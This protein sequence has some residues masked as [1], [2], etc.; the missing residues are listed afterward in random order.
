MNGPQCCRLN[1]TNTN[2]RTVRNEETIPAP[3]GLDTSGSGG[4]RILRSVR[5][6]SHSCRRPTKTLERS[7]FFWRSGFR[8][9][10]TCPSVSCYSWI[11]DL[12]TFCSFSQ[13]LFLRPDHVSPWQSQRITL[14]IIRVSVLSLFSS[15][16]HHQ[17]LTR[18]HRHFV[19]TTRDTSLR[20]TNLFWG[21]LHSL[22]I[23]RD[24]ISKILLIPPLTSASF[25][26]VI[27]LPWYESLL[28]SPIST[29]LMCPC[30]SHSSNPPSFI[31]F[32]LNR[33][34]GS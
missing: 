5:G 31:L 33:P 25:T 1:Q 14:P 29:N 6:S 15:R 9:L 24:L 18:D 3:C 17:D 11:G 23:I 2:K 4:R 28:I 7:G 20:F 30:F 8:I 13:L 32:D 21:Y 16:P 22:F 10:D 12:V 34:Q 19:F 27:I 26:R